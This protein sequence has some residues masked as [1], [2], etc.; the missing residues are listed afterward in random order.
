MGIKDHKETVQCHPQ[1]Y[2][3]HKALALAQKAFTLDE[4]P[5]G[6]LV[7]APDGAIIG[8]GFNEIEQRH[9]QNAH[10]EVLAINEANL[11]LNDWRLEGCWLYVTL[12]PCVMCMTLVKL[13]RMDGVV[14][15]ASSPLFGYSLNNEEILPLYKKKSLHIISGIMKDNATS[16]LRQF[17]QNKR[18]EP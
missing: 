16:V 2:Y 17:F 3:M 9:Q 18:G 10:A 7:V 14:Y 12:E 4:V 8:Q 11:F 1:E 13:S 5:I 15:G 6:A